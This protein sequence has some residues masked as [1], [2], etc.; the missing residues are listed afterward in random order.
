MKN[1]VRKTHGVKQNTRG[2][3]V[4]NTRLSSGEISHDVKGDNH[5]QSISIKPREPS[6]RTRIRPA[7]LSAAH[8]TAPQSKKW[9]WWYRGKWR[10][11]GLFAD[12]T[13]PTDF[14][15]DYNP[16]GTRGALS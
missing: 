7:S 11:L 13:A 3:G 1:Q 4:W 9:W 2:S 12:P 10:W 15:R 5:H 6:N 8:R 14:V 16:S